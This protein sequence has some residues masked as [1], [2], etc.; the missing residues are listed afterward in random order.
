MTAQKYAV[1]DGVDVVNIILLD[2]ADA[3]TP[4]DGHQLLPVSDDVSIG[5]RRAGS[6]WLP[7]EEPQVTP[8]PVEDP[9]VTAAKNTAVEELMALGITE[10]TARRIAGL[11]VEA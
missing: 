9:D 4:P 3:Y 5:W 2:E 10:A 1:L 7:L 8:Q 11:P 6:V